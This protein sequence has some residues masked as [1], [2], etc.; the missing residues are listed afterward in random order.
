MT[1]RAEI[2]LLKQQ[3]TRG[4]LGERVESLGSTA[5]RT[6]VA[7]DEVADF[8]EVRSLGRPVGGVS[9]RAGGTELWA[10]HSEARVADFDSPRSEPATPRRPK[11]SISAQASDAVLELAQGM[12]GAS[13]SAAIGALRQLVR[14]QAD[15]RPRHAA[16]ALAIADALIAT[17]EAPN[18]VQQSEAL[19]T[20]ALLLTDS[21]I[22]ITDER[23]AMNT[24]AR[25]GVDRY[26]PLDEGPLADLLG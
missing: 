22:S 15:Q 19:R 7:D 25:A 13:R 16:V 21:Y 26:A 11:P 10:S 6:K 14:V 1:T 3:K 5:S 20:A 17:P 9:R 8:R 23:A 4:R 2:I 12:A 18:G 24:L